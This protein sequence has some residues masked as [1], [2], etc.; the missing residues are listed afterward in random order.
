MKKH[1]SIASRRVSVIGGDP[2][3]AP[4]N[5]EEWQKSVRENIGLMDFTPDGFVLIWK[6]FPE[7]EEKLKRG[8]DAYVKAH[9]LTIIPK[10]IIETKYIEG[11]QFASDHGSGAKQNLALFKPAESR[12]Y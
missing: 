12:S 10:N 1:E 5:M 11:L 7:H 3:Y 6:L 9:Q 4:G 8:F 2:Q